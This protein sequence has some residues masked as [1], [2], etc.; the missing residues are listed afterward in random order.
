MSAPGP[1]GPLPIEVHGDLAYSY[2]VFRDLR[3]KAI[4]AHSWP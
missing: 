4:R 2:S 3:K 1:W